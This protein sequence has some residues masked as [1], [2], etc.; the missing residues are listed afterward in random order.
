LEEKER[1]LSRQP[2]AIRMQ[3]TDCSSGLEMKQSRAGETAPLANIER[4]YGE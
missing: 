1:E 4:K 3:L 2:G